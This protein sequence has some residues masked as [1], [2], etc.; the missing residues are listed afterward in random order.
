MPTT[1]VVCVAM[2]ASAAVGKQVL[3]RWAGHVAGRVC[4][5]WEDLRDGVVLLRIFQAVWPAPMER[6]KIASQWRDIVR[7]EADIQR[8]W[9]V[10]HTLFQ[11]VKLPMEVCLLFLST[12]YSSLLLSA[13][14][15]NLIFF[16]VRVC[17]C[18]PLSYFVVFV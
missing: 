17:V 12:I 2:T 5:R 18:V 9:D 14:L 4:T 7:F 15:M 16:F 11:E 13:C 1:A 8:N 10:L 3:L 6:G